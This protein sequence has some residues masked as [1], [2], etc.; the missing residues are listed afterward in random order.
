[1]VINNSN[2]I[3]INIDCDNNNTG[4]SFTVGTNQRS[5]DSNNKLF[6]VLE[7]GTVV[8]P[9]GQIQF[10]ATQNASS[11]ANT[12]DDY[13]EGTWP[14]TDGSGASLSITFNNARYTKIG[15]LVYV[16]VSTIVY[17][18][19]ASAVSA[20]IAGLPFANLSGDVASNALVSGNAFANRSLVITNSTTVYFYAD[21]STGASTNAQ[22]SGATIYGWSAVYQ[23]S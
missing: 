9:F 19:T 17:P 18:A 8:L 12:L 2:S 22:L 4:E 16:S 21:A 20:V 7:S 15:R 6:E 13:E 10:P 23:T 3:R 14:A 1:M 5:I 11:N